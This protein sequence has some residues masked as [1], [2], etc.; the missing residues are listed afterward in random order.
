MLLLKLDFGK[1]IH[2]KDLGL[3][4]RHWLAFDGGT[5]DILKSNFALKKIN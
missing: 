5:R 4:S 2:G 1:T 3:T